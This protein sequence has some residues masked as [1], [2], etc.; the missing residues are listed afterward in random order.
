MTEICSDII[1]AQTKSEQLGRVLKVPIHTVESIIQQDSKSEDRLFHVIDAFVKQIDTTPT[2]RVILAA[3]RN[4]LVNLPRLAENIEKKYGF[5]APRK[6][7]TSGMYFT[8]CTC[9]SL[10]RECL[11]CCLPLLVCTSQ[12]VHVIL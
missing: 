2:W 5:V 7:L 11:W 8:E 4:P 6:E 10:K 12:S 3:L 1:A 9:Y